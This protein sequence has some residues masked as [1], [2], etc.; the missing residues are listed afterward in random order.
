M[1]AAKMSAASE[2]RRER[3][4][5][6]SGG[7]F[8]GDGS[9]KGEVYGDTDAVDAWALGRDKEV[10]RVCGAGAKLGAKAGQ[11]RGVWASRDAAATC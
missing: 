2:P 3:L 7:G 6:E 5:A 9:G 11:G 8:S 1:G 4:G 10:E